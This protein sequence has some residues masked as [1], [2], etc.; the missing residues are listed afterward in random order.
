MKV[1]YAG[2]DAGRLAYLEVGTFRISLIT[3]SLFPEVRRSL[4]E[5]KEWGLN[6]SGLGIEKE[7]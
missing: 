2:S 7:L 4:L 3:D 1:W 5:R 6:F